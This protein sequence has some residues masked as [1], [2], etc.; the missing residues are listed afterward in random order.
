MFEVF[1]FHL[2]LS[3][4]KCELY[5]IFS[6][7]VFRC[8]W[9]S[10]IEIYF[11]LSIDFLCFDK[12]ASIRCLL[13][14]IFNFSFKFCLFESIALTFLTNSSYIVFLAKSYFTTLLSLLKSAGVISNLSKSIL[15]YRKSILSKSIISMSI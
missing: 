14:T 7:K 12:F 3:L 2:F 13:I 6:S 10:W 11:C 4:I 1:V 8:F 5:L 9:H 15:S